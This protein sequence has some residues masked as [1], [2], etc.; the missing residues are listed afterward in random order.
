MRRQ[1][2][3]WLFLAP[4]LL[5]L[6]VTG[7]VPFVYVLVT[8]FLNWNPVGANPL[9]TWTGVE[10]FRRLVFDEAFLGAMGRTVV[11]TIVTVTLQLILG[12][13]LAGMLL[14]NF[15]A[16]P[17]FRTIHALPLV[18]APIVVGAMWKLLTNPGLGP[19][20]YFLRQFFGFDYNVSRYAD[21]AFW[22][23]IVMDVWH[24]TPFV[25]LVILAGLSAMPKEPIESAR[26][27]GANRVQIFRHITLPLLSPVLLTVVFLRVMDALRIVD[28]VWMLTGGGPGTATRY[29]GIHIWRVVFPQTSYGYGSAMSILLLYFTVVIS[30]LLYVTIMGKRQKA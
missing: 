29:V 18:I 28:E 27:D 22:T 11:F 20:P 8:G 21:H 7:L 3:A 13:V 6:F 19:L 12:F 23:I 30:W 2:T 14:R 17:L 16:K 10:N 5:V 24:W 15:A 25:T 4:S 9:P 1:R 26:V